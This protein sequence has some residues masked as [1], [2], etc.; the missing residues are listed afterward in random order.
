LTRPERSR[1]LCAAIGARPDPRNYAVLFVKR[2]SA[3]VNVICQ[4]ESRILDALGVAARRLAHAAV[5]DRRLGPARQD[6]AR[7]AAQPEGACESMAR[8]TAFH[9]RLLK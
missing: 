3:L 2:A 1:N 5:V 6:I 8:R 4:R 7:R 9:A